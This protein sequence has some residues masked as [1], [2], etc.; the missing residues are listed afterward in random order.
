MRILYLFSFILILQSISFS[1]TVV[2][3]A[4]TKRNI[5]LPVDNFTDLSVKG[6][7]KS[8]DDIISL[9]D[10]VYYYDW[11]SV[12]NSWYA[13]YRIIY[14]YDKFGE[15]ATEKQDFFSFMGTKMFPYLLYQK[16]YFP[17]GSLKDQE[18]SIY[19]PLQLKYL[20][21]TREHWDYDF[22]KNMINLEIT[23]RDEKTGEWFLGYCFRRVFDKHDNL[24]GIFEYQDDSARQMY[25]YKKQESVYN[26]NQKLTDYYDSIYDAASG[27]FWCN[28]VK[29]FKYDKNGN[30]TELITFWNYAIN[31]LAYIQQ[32]TETQY[33]SLGYIITTTYYSSSYSSEIILPGTRERIVYNSEMQ[34]VQEYIDKWNN[35]DQKW[36]HSYWKTKIYNSN[37][38]YF[39]CITKTW[40]NVNQ[41]Y[42]NDQLEENLYTAD[43]QPAEQN[44]YVWENGWNVKDKLIYDYDS[45]GNI[46]R[47]YSQTW[48]QFESSLQNK[49]KRE[50]YYSQKKIDPLPADTAFEM[51]VYPNPANDLLI[52]QKV[53]VGS[54][55]EVFDMKGSL[56]LKT[57]VH[58]A[59]TLINTGSLTD[60]AYVLKAVYNGSEKRT[61]FVK[62]E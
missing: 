37:P 38:G 62:V 18:T 47:I 5:I 53:P 52:V 28:Q 9:P 20:G 61:V 45:A 50:S 13:T 30:E 46:L 21:V 31:P 12:G 35:A 19:T 43:K 14:S 6:F 27:T 15:V 29:H 11:D 34:P 57:T 22:R 25:L 33:D 59:A 44:N 60:G 36:D 1:Q 16:S 8:S 40:N 42:I 2:L 7:L 55:L 3:T 54:A 32:K 41:T 48:N 10:S 4:G 26:S 39:Q 17:D 24:T 51:L 49:N 56:Q 58:E 23:Y